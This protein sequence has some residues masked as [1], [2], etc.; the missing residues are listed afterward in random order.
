MQKITAVLF[1]LDG[2]LLPMDQELF[3]QTYFRELAAKSGEIGLEADRLIQAVWAGTKAMVENDGSVT[4]EDRFWFVF[5]ER[6]KRKK[7][8]LEP[9]FD[10]FYRNEFH[11]VKAVTQPAPHALQCV[12]RLKEKGYRLALATNPIF[13][14]VATY[15]RIAW[16]GLDPAD[17]ELVTTYENTCYSKPNPAYYREILRALG[18]AE[19]ECL[20]I[21][22]NVKE[23]MCAQEMGMECF[24]LTECLIAS[25]DDSAAQYRNGGFADLL[26]LI[27]A[28]PPV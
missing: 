11:R 22:N 4:N 1:D 19:S 24:L 25:E 8:E 28:L 21:G 17:F 13:P 26:G 5:E 23:D 18:L 12:K 27:E 9:V 2:T 20:M 7:R 10:L 16:A 14:R 3:V 15:G 6:T